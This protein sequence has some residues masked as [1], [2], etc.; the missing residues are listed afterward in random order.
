MSLALV[1][2]FTGCATTAHNSQPVS[3]VRPDGARLT[4]SQA[5]S[6]AKQAAER[7]GF[8]LTDY[9][10]PDALFEIHRGWRSQFTD[11][12]VGFDSKVPFPGD[13]F[14]VFVDD[15]TQTAKL[16]F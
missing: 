14:T 10:E 4:Q 7:E 13:H 5:I 12:S 15:Q 11:W 8:H 1:A 16:S 9:K 3:D 2:A 6:L